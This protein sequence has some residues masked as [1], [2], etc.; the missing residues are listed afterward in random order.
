MKNKNTAFIMEVGWGVWEITTVLERMA[1][2][3]KANDMV[4]LRGGHTF[5]NI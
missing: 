3:T 1:V 5:S 2:N 4:K